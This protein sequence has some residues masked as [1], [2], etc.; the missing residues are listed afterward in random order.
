MGNNHSSNRNLILDNDHYIKLNN[1]KYRY[2][3]SNANYLESYK[4]DIAYYSCGQC[5]DC[6]K[7]Y[8]SKKAFYVINNM[9][10]TM[11]HSTFSGLNTIQINN[12]TFNIPKKIIKLELFFDNGQFTTSTDILV[13]C[14]NDYNNKNYNHEYN[15]N[16]YYKACI[17]DDKYNYL[18]N[19][20]FSE[21]D[22]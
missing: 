12:N 16:F 15:Y 2:I 4:P 13:E 22:S 11:G 8:E 21:L 9:M 19:D 14:K 17:N 18:A 6:I 1:Q 5:S 3:L 10:S 20:F 7:N